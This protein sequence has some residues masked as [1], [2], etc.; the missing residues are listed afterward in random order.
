M[1]EIWKDIP[2]YEGLYQASNLGNIRSINSRWGKRSTPRIVKQQLTKKGYKRISLSKNNKHNLFM[3]HRLI[4]E[5]FNDKIENDLEIN[6][7]N[8]NRADNNIKNLELLNHKDNVRY[9]K[10]IKVY[11]YDLNGNFIKKWNST[12]DIEREINIDH[13]QI[14]DN[15]RKK[16]KTCKGFIFKY[17]EEE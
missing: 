10:A 12:R 15:C 17:K 2:D 1:K 5:T 11:Q 6:H 9:S 14:S 7:K 4:Y 16:Q 3:V 8:Y 13:R